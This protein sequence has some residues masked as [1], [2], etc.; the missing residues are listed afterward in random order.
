MSLDGVLLMSLRFVQRP[1]GLSLQVGQV[2]LGAL[3]M[4]LHLWVGSSV[5]ILAWKFRIESVILARVRPYPFL[6]HCLAFCHHLV[7]HQ[8]RSTSGLDKRT[9]SMKRSKKS[10][11]MMTLSLLIYL[12]MR[13]GRERRERRER[14]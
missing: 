5:S 1:N 7:S 12:M 6:L 14:R 10:R 9:C 4:R 3:E 2:Y 13:S 11:A 8:W